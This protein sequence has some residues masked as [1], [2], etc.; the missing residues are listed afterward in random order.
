MKRV[1][2][3]TRMFDLRNNLWLNFRKGISTS[4][5]RLLSLDIATTATNL[6]SHISTL[7]KEV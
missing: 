7:S 5:S 1:F 2:I 6:V 3:A 4:A